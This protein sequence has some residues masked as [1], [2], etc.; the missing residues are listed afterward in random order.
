MMNL[1]FTGLQRVTESADLQEDKQS[2]KGLGEA[3]LSGLLKLLVWAGVVIWICFI[4]PFGKIRQD[5]V[6]KSF[7]DDDMRTD[8]ITEDMP[9]IEE[10]IP[11]YDKLESIGIILNRDDGAV[12]EGTLS[13]KVYDS[14]VQLIAQKDFPIAEME[15]GS[16]TDIP[17]ALS[18]EPG[19]L[20]YYRI[21]VSN[22]KEGA[23][24]L[25]YRSQSGCGPE[26]NQVLHYGGT[27]IEDGSPVSR[28][29]YGKPLGILQI[30]TY[31]SFGILLGI[32][33]S[34]LIDCIWKRKTEKNAVGKI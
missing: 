32:A 33:L 18:V 3:G 28:Y 24:T 5:Y 4:W 11:Q 14:Q 15:D 31:D 1:K 8:V 26:E 23:P 29:E 20:Y 16:F 9:I 13:F 12:T 30:L 6:S 7:A 25:S 17:L 21:E 22:P 10:F 34:S 27:V 2:G 19:A